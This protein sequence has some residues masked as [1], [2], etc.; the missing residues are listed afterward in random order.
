[1]A[2]TINAFI[3]TIDYLVAQISDPVLLL[4]LCIHL[5]HSSFE[6]TV[7][8]SDNTLS[9]QLLNCKL[10]YQFIVFIYIIFILV[11]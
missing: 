11:L 5:V 8:L 10:E 2:G 4:L 9:L 3:N 1:M 6:N 7:V